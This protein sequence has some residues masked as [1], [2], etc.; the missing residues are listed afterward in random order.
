[1]RLARVT[2]SLI[3]FPFSLLPIACGV[4]SP[5]TVSGSCNAPASF[6]N[7]TCTGR[8]L[9]SITVCPTTTTAASGEAQFTATGN[10]T[11]PPYSVTPQT[12]QWSACANNT[13]TSNV[14]VTSA[15]LAQCQSGAKGT[16]TVNAFVLTE[17]N[18]FSACGEGCTIRG[19]AQLTCP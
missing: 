3:L 5:P 14:T 11:A 2:A 9:A 7:S 12:V 4:A 19:T 1:M 13:P 10:Y 16:F 17:C 15:G 6:K 8:C 18:A